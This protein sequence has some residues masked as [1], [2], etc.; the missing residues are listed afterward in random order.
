M[1]KPIILFLF[2]VTNSFEFKA[3]QYVQWKAD[4]VYECEY[5]QKY[6]NH[7][8]KFKSGVD[9]T[10]TFMENDSVYKFVIDI[11]NYELLDMYKYYA[12]EIEV[13]FEKLLTHV[14]YEF[15]IH[16]EQSFLDTAG[17]GNRIDYYDDTLNE[18]IVLY[19]EPCAS[20]ETGKRVA[21]LWHFTDWDEHLKVW[22]KSRYMES[23]QMPESS[24][25]KGQ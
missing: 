6:Q 14:N 2:I 22:A 12:K 20:C 24:L 25:V 7:E 10:L 4:T 15:N 13:P 21:C 17:M 9:A 19:F 16:G 18:K 8:S 3:Q 1:K 23:P 5:N 11:N